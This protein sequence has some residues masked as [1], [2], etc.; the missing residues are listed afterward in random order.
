MSLTE[1]AMKVIGITGRSGSGKSTLARALERLGAEVLDGDQI[2]AGLLAPGSP[3]LLKVRDAFGP[4]FFRE[5]GSLDR[6][7]LGSLV[8]SDERSLAVLDG[9][10]HPHFRRLVEEE[11]RKLERQDRSPEIAVLDAAVLFEAGLDG[12]CDIVVAVMCD[13]ETMASRI[14]QRDG[15]EAQ[16][17]LERINA[18]K[19]KLSD[20]CM[21]RKA[22]IVVISRGDAAEMDAWAKRIARIAKGGTHGH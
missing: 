20:Y 11:V 8:F 3:L 5:D 17:S 21:A 12:I 19:S 4:E 10:V 16:A 18:Q 1:D 6:K 15:I 7:K 9:I 13:D 22:D 2:A 14:S